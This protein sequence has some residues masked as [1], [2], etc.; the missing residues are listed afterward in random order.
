VVDPRTSTIV[1]ARWLGSALSLDPNSVG[2]AL[3]GSAALLLI[4]AAFIR[5]WASSYLHAKVVYASQVQTAS[6]V[7]DGPYRHVRNPL[8][9]ANVLMAMGLG[10]MMSRTG[11]FV[12]VAAMLIFSYRLIRREESEL[13]ASQGDQY[14]RYRN[15]VPRLWP[16]PWARVASSGRPARWRDGFRA[17]SWYWGF[18]AALTTFALTLKFTLFVVI[19][20]SSLVLFWVSSVVLRKT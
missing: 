8:Y 13:S 3:F 1:F 9:F 18:A 20:A 19:L 12:A 14:L 15:A 5:T 2:R 6:L 4:V 16:S 7:A 10:T 11:C 17:E